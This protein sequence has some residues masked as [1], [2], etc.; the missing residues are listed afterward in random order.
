MSRR[1]EPLRRDATGKDLDRECP[2]VACLQGE[3]LVAAGRTGYAVARR[4]GG[5]HQHIA[6]KEG[7]VGH[8]DAGARPRPG[9]PQDQGGLDG[10]SVA[11]GIGVVAHQVVE[12]AARDLAGVRS[13]VDDAALRGRGD[14]IARAP[15]DRVVEL[16]A[17]QRA[18]RQVEQRSP[19]APAVAARQGGQRF[20][21]P[22]EP[23]LGLA[24]APL[25]RRPRAVHAL[26]CPGI[27]VRPAELSRGERRGRRASPLGRLKEL[28]QAGNPER[29][30]RFELEQQ[31]AQ[32]HQLGMRGVVVGAHEDRDV[33]SRRPLHQRGAHPVPRGREP[34]GIGR[35]YRRDLVSIGR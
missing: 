1:L 33:L 11:R 34:V 18:P 29:I 35:K 2:A 3:R 10:A 23:Q 16:R 12:R 32:P 27:A 20:R 6:A 31:I 15:R 14:V 22:F 21:H 9:V 4:G 7:D 30:G 28:I 19:L 17:H 8:D 5:T 25:E 26:Q 13:Y 24:M